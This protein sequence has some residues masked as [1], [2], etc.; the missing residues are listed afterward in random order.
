MMDRE[1]QTRWR[2][3]FILNTA[4]RSF[5]WALLLMTY[6]VQLHKMRFKIGVGIVGLAMLF[7]AHY[8]GI[9]CLKHWNL[10]HMLKE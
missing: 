7:C 8:A 6:W 5:S 2:L 1:K 10:Q 4:K 3:V 9:F